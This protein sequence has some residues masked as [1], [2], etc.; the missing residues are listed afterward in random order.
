MSTPKQALAE[1]KARLRAQGY[2]PAPRYGRGVWV[3]RDDC[4]VAEIKQEEDYAVLWVEYAVSKRLLL[5]GWQ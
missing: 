2:H 1:I 4:T 5:G 3:H